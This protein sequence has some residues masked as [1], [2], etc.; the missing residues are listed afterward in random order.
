MNKVWRGWSLKDNGENRRRKQEPS[1]HN[2]EFVTC[3]KGERLSKTTP[4]CSK[5][6]K[7][8]EQVY[9]EY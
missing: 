7:N 8:F 2:V 4:N 6:Q 5:I 3:G 9:R 1:E